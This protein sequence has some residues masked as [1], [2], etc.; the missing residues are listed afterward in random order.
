MRFKSRRETTNFFRHVQVLVAVL[1]VRYLPTMHNM[2]A[3][4]LDA[5]G[6][7]TGRLYKRR[8]GKTKRAQAYPSPSSDLQPQVVQPRS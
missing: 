7:T 3:T 8:M 1:L 6:C 5:M 2:T 4:T